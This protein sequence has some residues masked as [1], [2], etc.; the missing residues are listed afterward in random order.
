MTDLLNAWKLDISGAAHQIYQR[1]ISPVVLTELMLD[2]IATIESAAA[3]EK[4][5]ANGK[6]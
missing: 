6:L 5:I 1:S 2:R 4:E 3:A